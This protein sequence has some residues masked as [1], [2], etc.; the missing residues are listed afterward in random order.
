ED[1]LAGRL[2]ASDQDAFCQRLLLTSE[3]NQRI[4]VINA[5]RAFAAQQPPLPIAAIAKGA[6]ARH[7][8]GAKL[9]SFWAIGRS[10]AIVAAAV[11]VVIVA[12]AAFWLLRYSSK[13]RPSIDMLTRRQEIERE[14]SRL[15][16]P[17]GQPLPPE[18]TTPAANISPVTLN[19]NILSR[20]NGE[21]TKVEI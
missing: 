7:L 17:S 10:K 13:T 20:S 4:G 1:Y 11:I 12:V 2:P 3:Q 15:N 16:P 9:L 5:L 6:S 8:T 21:L 18:L 19:P 14:V